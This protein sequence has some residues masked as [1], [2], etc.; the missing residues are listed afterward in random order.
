MR[1]HQ[2]EV[3]GGM[4]IERDTPIEMDVASTVPVRNRAVVISTPYTLR[5]AVLLTVADGFLD[6]HTYLVRGGVF[7]N[8]Q[9]G[10]VIFFA[11]HLSERRWGDSLSRLW[12]MF[13][14]IAGVVLSSHIKSGRVDKVVAQPLRWTMASQAA[15]LAGFGFLPATLPHSLVV[16]PISF[17]AG[18]QIGVFRS[19]GDLA[20]MPLATTGN[21][22]RVVEAGYDFFVEKNS[23]SR[24]AFMVYADVIG[25]FAAGAI[26]GAFT[27]R[28]WGLHAIWVPAGLLAVTLVLFVI[29]EREGRRRNSGQTGRSHLLADI[30]HLPFA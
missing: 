18:I 19:I 8:M 11:I 22:M 25:A 26:A 2:S 21:L 14:F 28:A 13:A 30:I 23:S 29:D 10:N 27:T 4:R 16:V 7:A 1:E 20:Y 6:A 12:P 9:T 5:F 3:R 17:L 15:V 24:R